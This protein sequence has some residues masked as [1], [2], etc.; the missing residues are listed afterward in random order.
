M[1]GAKTKEKNKAKKDKKKNQHNEL[2]EKK[3]AKP[4]VEELVVSYFPNHYNR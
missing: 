1:K 4:N 2:M 3:E